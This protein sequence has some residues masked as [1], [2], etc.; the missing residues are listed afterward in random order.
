MELGIYN[1]NF[2]FPMEY[3]C[4]WVIGFFLLFEFVLCIFT[5][6]KIITTQTALFYLRNAPLVDKKFN[7]FFKAKTAPSHSSRELAV[8]LKKL[9]DKTAYNN[10]WLK[11]PDW[12]REDYAHNSFDGT[13]SFN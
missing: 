12:L 8:G 10:K 1:Q 2:L 11:E 13:Q 4:F 3:S 6:R 7:A 5:I 9:K